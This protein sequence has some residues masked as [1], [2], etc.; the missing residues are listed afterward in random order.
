MPRVFLIFIC[1]IL[2][3]ILSAQSMDTTQSRE[4]SQMYIQR[5]RNYLSVKM[6]FNNSTEYFAVLNEANDIELKPNTKLQTK[7]FFSY[8]FINLVL[9]F[10][11]AFLPGNNDD[12]QK[13]KSDIFSIDVTIDKKNWIQTLSY[14]RIKGFYLVNSDEYIPDWNEGE[15]DYI[16][17][18]ELF[19]NNFSGQTAYRFN[20][21]FSFQAIER[22]TERQVRS[23]GTFMP[24]LSY[25]YY[26]FNNRIE[27]TGSNS[28]QKSNN[29]ETNL[30]LGYFYTQVLNRK[31]YLSLGAAG[32]GGLVHVNLLTRLS[33]GRIRTKNTH[34]I[35]RAEGIA[36]LG[37]NSERFFAGVHT[38]GTL[39]DYPQEE[40][41]VILNEAIKIQFFVG[42]RFNAP[43]PLKRAIDKI[44]Y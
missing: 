19:Y 20:P 13:G 6:A 38:I 35:L 30:Q 34:P 8:R 39:E 12:S 1:I 27:L 22:Q 16:Q 7:F 10:S 44:P 25:R 31:F 37:Y 29:F 3:Q 14:N 36:A 33:D 15:S 41:S 43:K 42:Y 11:P 18:P 2:S 32:G 24:I 23:A 28:S 9:G 40:T 21:N 4:D 17:F 26:I 5:Y